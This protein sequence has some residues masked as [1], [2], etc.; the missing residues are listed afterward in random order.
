MSKYVYVINCEDSNGE[1]T[2]CLGVFTTNEGAVNFLMT[3]CYGE[4]GE[5][6]CCSALICPDEQK[7]RERQRKKIAEAN[8]LENGAGG[9]AIE[10][11]ELK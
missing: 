10:K 9:Y 7:C 8:F 3:D 5:G 1:E 11:V 4:E 2:R 6:C